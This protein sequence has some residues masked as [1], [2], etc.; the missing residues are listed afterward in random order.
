MTDIFISYAKEDQ[1]IASDLA[2]RLYEEDGWE[3]FWDRTIEAGAEWNEE[4]QRALHNARCVL[5]LW[6][7][8]SRKS[9]WVRGE[10]AESYEKDVY[11]PV[12]IDE[13]DPPRLFR[14]VQAQ[15]IAGWVGKRNDE[16][17][18][19][20]RLAIASRIGK[21]EMYGNLEQV[22]NG[23]P[24]KDTHLH[25]VHS[26]WRVDKE[27]KFGRMPYQIHLI[28]YGHITAL[29][30]IE[31]VEYHLPGY[32]E[33]H[34]TQPGG[35]PESLF[36]LKELANG[37]SIVQA[38]VKLNSQPPGHSRILRLSRLINMSESGP[39]LF[40]DFIRRNNLHSRFREILKGLPAAEA[41][42]ER[43]LKTLDREAVVRWLMNDGY[44]ETMAES[45]VA[46]VA[47]RISH[48]T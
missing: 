5:V 4:I 15:S 36:E 27:S 13:T 14:H 39:R 44:G 7:V 46:A 37:F 29:A 34:H 3:I 1:Q 19:R 22:A 24:V 43:L 48:S 32:P 16:E 30:R 45:A 6:S 9:F 21:L 18:D 8:D 41:E 42:A 2:A 28:V 31:S 26:C 23:A 40:D 33:G 12:R 17:F 47:A 10:A 25:L 20:L 38:H 35:P 11:L